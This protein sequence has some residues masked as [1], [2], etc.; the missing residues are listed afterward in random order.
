MKKLFALLLCAAMLLS[1][2]P[3]GVLA[4]EPERAAPSAG[5]EEASP[6]DDGQS[7]DPQAETPEEFDCRTHPILDRAPAEAGGASL[8]TAA[9]S[10]TVTVELPAKAPAGADL[11]VALLRQA[12]IDSGGMVTQE[13]TY[14]YG[15]RI[16]LSA[17]QTSVSFTA[18]NL[19]AGS[20]IVEAHAYYSASAIPNDDLFFNGDGSLADN[21]FVAKGFS[22][23]EGA[24]VSKTVAIPTAART[25]SGELTFSSPTAKAM[26]VTVYSTSEIGNSS[27]DYLYSYLTIPAGVKQAAFSLGTMKTWSYG[28]EFS[29]G[30]AWSYYCV[31]NTLKQNY[32]HINIFDLSAGSV[33]GLSANGDVLLKSDSGS[34]S[35]GIG[36]TMSVDL[37]EALSEGREYLLAAFQA[38]SSWF[39]SSSWVYAEKGAATIQTRSPLQLRPN[40]DYVFGYVDATEADGWSNNTFPGLRYLAED[41]GVTSD[42]SQA[43]VYSFTEDGSVSLK[44]PACWRIT[45]TV[46]RDA[47]LL[48]MRSV[49]ALVTADFPDGQCWGARAVFSPGEEDASYTIYVPR[50]QGGVFT[51]SAAYADSFRNFD[52]DENAWVHPEKTYPALSGDTA[53][54]AITLKTP[55]AVS[56]TV[57]LPKAAPDGGL[58]VSLSLNDYY[59]PVAYVVVPAGETSASFS[60]P[61]FLKGSC[62]CLASPIGS[63]DQFVEAGTEVQ[64]NNGSASGITLALG[65]TALIS[66]TISLPD[67]V[68]SAGVTM[69]FYAVVNDNDKLSQRVS[70]R[71]GA[72]SSTAY[73]LRVPDGST[74][75]YFNLSVYES[76]SPEIAQAS[77]YVDSDWTVG[78]ETGPISVNGGH[79]GLD[80][81][82]KPATVLRGT[83]VAED[84]SALTVNT[85]SNY[86][87][88]YF[89]KDTGIG[90][91]VSISIDA[92]GNWSAGIPTD[93]AGDLTL[94]ISFW[95]S[96]G[97]NILRGDYYYTT[98][99]KAVTDSD[100]AAVLTVP[101]EGASGITIPVRT[102]CLITGQVR[103]PDGASVSVDNGYQI[104]LTV[105]AESASRTYYGYCRIANG[106]DAYDYTILVPK[107]DTYTIRYT[108]TAWD[109]SYGTT[110]VVFNETIDADQPVQVSSESNVTGPDFT[111]SLAKVTIRGTITSPIQIDS[112][113]NLIVTVTTGHSIYHTNTLLYDSSVSYFVVI[114]ES[115]DSDW[116]RV[117]YSFHSYDTPPGLAQEGY[118]TSD[119]VST[120]SSDAAQFPFSD[121]GV[122]SFT[123]ATCPPFHQ[124]RIYIPAEV[125]SSFALNVRAAG[126]SYSEH[127]LRVE[128]SELPSDSTGRY[129]EYGLYDDNISTGSAYSI[130][131]QA[132]DESGVL[133]TNEFYVDSSGGLTRDYYQRKSFTYSG[134]ANTQDLTLLTWNDGSENNIIQSE[135]GFIVEG[136]PDD[137]LIWSYTYPGECESLTIKFSSRGDVDLYCYYTD[138]YGDED[139]AYAD[140]GSTV[141]VPGS[142]F[143]LRMYLNNSY[144][145]RYY[146]FAV[147]SITPNG[148]TSPGIGYAGA[149][150]DK[151]SSDQA[152]LD[153]LRENKTL[154][155]IVTGQEGQSATA[156]AAIYDEDGRY[157]GIDTKPL[158]LSP[159]GRQVTFQ[160]DNTRDAAQVQ[161]FLWDSGNSPLSESRSFGT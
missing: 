13:P 60:I 37:P 131:L 159:Q 73:A 133:D 144:G 22:L 31:D 34:V 140:A 52:P 122:H 145:D 158:T 69:E 54:D 51:L 125:T 94:Y 89:N 137:P 41:G 39:Q 70:I 68:T 36:V 45:G 150:T 130:S 47:S 80:F 83:V 16:T 112:S 135:H 88:H 105:L 119:G 129:V 10:A 141:T 101:P 24:S 103:L 33:T 99:S 30:D 120:D 32:N 55:G 106:K 25:I 154:T 123:L 136:S 160:L 146:G 74:L 67:G 65:E 11:Y 134:S 90:D 139:Y 77:F 113:C 127:N 93:Q 61:S 85:D 126:A 26:D 48:G 43:K 19:S 63:S 62:S 81:T 84:G 53:A 82:L 132:Y 23:A 1:L 4:V 78:D 121:G 2:L 116:Y 15:N 156:A 96:E 21:R 28:L 97:S 152:V 75:S 38:G 7:A 155:A 46:T 111:L 95:Q 79:S 18:K 57:T 104:S 86:S 72:G 142:A 64:I 107:N 17:G 108:G 115:D 87:L 8:M 148:V 143:T 12:E 147:E 98:G 44:E 14:V 56:G 128:P 157:L 117:Q 100:D 153:Q 92:Q 91:S 20:Y 42:R 6:G 27:R 110:N 114:P 138:S 66:G 3:A 5:T 40:R 35:S 161:L 118:L 151:G 71:E 76:A 102:G 109:S 59:D 124:G 9:G 58:A 50:S 149:V 29:S 49:A